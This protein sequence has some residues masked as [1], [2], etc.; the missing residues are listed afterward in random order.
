MDSSRPPMPSGGAAAPGRPIRELPDPSD[1]PFGVRFAIVDVFGTG[2]LTGNPLAVLDLMSFES[3]DPAEDWLAAVA[4]EMNQ[5]ET[6]FVLPATPTAD[7]RLRSF[8]AG[9]VEVYGAGHNALGAWWW[10]LET[11][12]ITR[13]GPGVTLVQEIG[14]HD[15][16]I[17]VV[18]RELV[19][20]QSHPVYGEAP[21][22]SALVS[23]IG[24]ATGDLDPDVPPRVVG[25][26][27]DHLMIA[28]RD[29]DSMSSCR[30]DKKALVDVTT[31]VGA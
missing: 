14:G 18:G 6:T 10:L 21:G 22:H 2:P 7:A 20:R 16:E 30:P 3:G 4:R 25:T 26:G 23:A 1:V 9:G 19:M 24:L 29:P 28:V 5:A 13:H 11:G 8:T 17:E 15:L 27:A 12:R 31:G